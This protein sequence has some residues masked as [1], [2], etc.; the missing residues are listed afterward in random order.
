M[1][2]KKVA[3]LACAAVFA[4]STLAGC[5]GGGNNGSTTA[6]ATTEAVKEAAAVAIDS[7]K[8]AETKEG[9]ALTGEPIK[10]GTIY[11]MYAGTPVNAPVSA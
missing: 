5:S 10:I 2:L 4:M 9:E 11:A 3:S 8:E 7:S 1:K 6:A